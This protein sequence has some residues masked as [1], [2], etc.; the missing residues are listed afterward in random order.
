[1]DRRSPEPSLSPK[2]Y[3]KLPP[4]QF[5][6]EIA[7]D[8]DAE[9]LLLA[10]VEKI[11]IESLLS[12]YPYHHRLMEQPSFLHALTRARGMKDVKTFKEF[13]IALEENIVTVRSYYRP[14]ADVFEVLSRA[15]ETRSLPAIMEGL[16]LLE[17]PLL[18]DPAEVRKGIDEYFDLVNGE[19][20]FMNAERRVVDYGNVP[21]EAL[22]RERPLNKIFPPPGSDQTERNYKGRHPGARTFVDP[23]DLS[24]PL[25]KTELITLI[26]AT[27]RYDVPFTF[28]MTLLKT[29]GH[30]KHVKRSHYMD[31]LKNQLARLIESLAEV[32]LDTKS[33]NPRNYFTLLSYVINEQSHLSP[34]KDSFGKYLDIVET[35][36]RLGLESFNDQ[37]EPLTDARLLIRL[38]AQSSK[39]LN[40]FDVVFT[41][42]PELINYA[43]ELYPLESASFREQVL[44]SERPYNSLL[45]LLG[46]PSLTQDEALSFMLLYGNGFSADQL[47]EVA[48]SLMV[49]FGL[50][51]E[52]IQY[53]LTHYGVDM[54]ALRNYFDADEWREAGFLLDEYLDAISEDPDKALSDYSEDDYY[55]SEHDY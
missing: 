18:L 26:I 28:L 33:Y 42:S 9:S 37:T 40:F 6:L 23:Q 1:M 54:D 41:G 31:E 10:L 8:P 51:R 35:L 29:V 47:T 48:A 38:D 46:R 12:F 15:V 11:D 24:A 49:D 39:V 4:S 36:V 20:Y 32:Q 55:D 21:S 52:F 13:V 50:Q 3:E 34:S 5:A 17:T 19:L 53:V 22:K 2:W 45:K 30:L 14:N 43:E 27:L 7:N 25:V 44:S 16:N